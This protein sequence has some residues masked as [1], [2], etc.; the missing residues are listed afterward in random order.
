[1]WANLSTKFW[2]KLYF[3]LQ[4]TLAETTSHIILPITAY[5][6]AVALVDSAMIPHFSYLVDL[7]HTSVYGN[8]YAIGDLSLCV[9]YALGMLKKYRVFFILWMK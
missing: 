1:M 2:K 9:S 4:L 5:G 7:R 8:V 6:F 3:L